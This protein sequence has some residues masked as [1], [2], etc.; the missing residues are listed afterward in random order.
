M[1]SAS[2]VSIDESSL[3][4]LS[5]GWRRRHRH[6]VVRLAIPGDRGDPRRARSD[7]RR[8]CRHRRWREWSPRR[9]SPPTTRCGP[10][11]DRWIAF[12]K[13][14][15][16]TVRSL[17]IIRTDG[18]GMRTVSGDLTHVGGPDTWSPDGKWIYFD[19]TGRVYRA[20][21]ADGFTQRLTEYALA[22]Y[23]PASSP[24]GTLIAFIVDQ[25]PSVL[26]PVRRQQRRDGC[27]SIARPRRERRLVGGRSLHPRAMEPD[28]PTRRTGRR[29]AGWKRVSGGLPV[30]RP[31][32]TTARRSPHV[33]RRGRLGP[34][35][36]ITAGPPGSAITPDGSVS[37]GPPAVRDSRCEDEDVGATAFERVGH[38]PRR[39][40]SRR[41][42]C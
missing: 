34:G 30:R 37:P 33:H 18:S 28:R 3:P 15:E 16:G 42:G 19:D 10:R 40:G 2:T 11:I 32:S 7:R 25:I 23:A 5:L 12:T 4:D 6:L 26:G 9:G 27:P 29:Q 41:C 8:R 21:V 24:D 17:A 20:N 13:E 38:A 14:V 31:V 36:T 22:A 35:S 1:W 39:S